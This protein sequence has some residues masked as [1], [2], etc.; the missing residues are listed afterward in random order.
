MA[1]AIIHGYANLKLNLGKFFC[2]VSEKKVNKWHLNG[3][4]NKFLRIRMNPA[5]QQTISIEELF[6]QH[7]EIAERPFQTSE[8]FAENVF[9]LLVTILSRRGI[10]LTPEQ[11]L[12]YYVTA[13]LLTLL[14]AA[15]AGSGE[16]RDL[17]NA[18]K[19]ACKQNASGGPSTPNA[20]SGPAPIVST[21]APEPKTDETKPQ[22]SS[23][24]TVVT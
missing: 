8:E 11:L 13:D 22:H 4:I 7:N 10:A 21:P 17:V 19:E 5:S 23:N 18:V 24:L 12:G 6:K 16:K 20:P 9:P 3:E 1:G 14:Q 15:V 2:T